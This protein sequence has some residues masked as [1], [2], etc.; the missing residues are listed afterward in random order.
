MKYFQVF[1]RIQAV[2]INCEFLKDFVKDFTNGNIYVSEDSK[3]PHSP[4]INN[5]WNYWVFIVGFW[6]ILCGFSI[7]LKN[8]E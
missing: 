3:F 4:C 1:P 8:F 5:D 7:K 6:E 2:I